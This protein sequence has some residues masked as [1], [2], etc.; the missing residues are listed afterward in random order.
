MVP[1]RYP[2]ASR[3]N[4]PDNHSAKTRPV[5]GLHCVK[6]FCGSFGELAAAIKSGNKEAVGAQ[7]AATGKNGCGACHMPYREK[8]S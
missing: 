3:R 7:R 8:L 2:T 5:I 4:R 1:T 6:P